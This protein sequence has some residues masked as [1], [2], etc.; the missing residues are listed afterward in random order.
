M[1]CLFVN[2]YQ[3]YPRTLKNNIHH[4]NKRGP[5]SFLHPETNHVIGHTLARSVDKT[6][7]LAATVDLIWLL[8]L[9]ILSF[10]FVPTPGKSLRFTRFRRSYVQHP[11]AVLTNHCQ[12]FTALLLDVH[13][14]KWPHAFFAAAYNIVNSKVGRQTNRCEIVINILN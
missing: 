9:N 5:Q 4:S 6:S 11:A 13:C 8:F 2:K 10:N 14:S 12:S 3:Q 7:V 1:L